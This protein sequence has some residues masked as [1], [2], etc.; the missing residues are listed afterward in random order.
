[1]RNAAP[2][3]VLFALSLAAGCGSS[4][5][6][7]SKQGP[8]PGD[9]CLFVEEGSGPAGETP[10]RAEV[11][12]SGLEVP[13]GVAFLP[14]G[15]ILV[16]ERP[17]GLRRIENGQLLPD[18]I[19]TVNITPE[20]EGGLLGIA[21]DP[22]FAA[23]RR[24]YLYFTAPGPKNR[25]ER[26]IVAED[27][28]SAA[29]DRLLL[30]GIPAA[31]S[32]DGGR[33]AFGP[34]GYLYA[35]TGDARTPESAQD[36]QA[37]SGKLLRIGTDGTTPADNPWPG[38]PAWAIGIRNCE[39][40]D[41]LDDGRVILADHG[42]SGEFGWRGHD[43]VSLVR[44]GD[45]LGWPEIKGCEAR[46][47]LV[48]PILSWRQAVPPG[49]GAIY[50]GAELPFRGVFLVGTLGSQH[51][52]RVVFSGDRVN[53]HEVY[54]QDQLGRIRTVIQGPDGGLYL[55]TSNC[56]GRAECP[57]EKDVLVRIRAGG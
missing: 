34:D 53:R 26:W 28:R 45:N 7:A 57:P 18:P 51:L 39:G 48:T 31:R 49:G 47:G 20:G 29:F 43:E 46:Q 32:H 36:P 41:F 52:H 3:V 42:P 24:L 4:G 35:C 12:A 13:W 9:G 33:L 27:G 56:D 5:C 23:N 17:G 54:F 25:I 11:V 50:R 10:L 2:L 1:M 19:A 8:A 38:S 37:L 55:T 6:T 14:D 15:A 44:K 16:A 22:A 21:A 40:F 30:D